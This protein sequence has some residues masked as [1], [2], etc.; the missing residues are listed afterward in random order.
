MFIEVETIND[1]KITLNVL[2]IASIA[3]AIDFVG[4]EMVGATSIAMV[5]GM[6]DGEY[7]IDT[8]SPNQWKTLRAFL[9]T[10]YTILPGGQVF[11]HSDINPYAVHLIKKNFLENKH[12][13]KGVFEVRCGNLFDIIQK[14]ERFDVIIFNPPYLPTTTQEKKGISEWYVRSFDGG[15]TG[16][17]ET[18]PFIKQVKYFLKKQGTAYIIHSSLS[19]KQKLEQLLKKTDLTYNIVKT[20]RCD[21]EILSVY[22]ISY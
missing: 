8:C 1:G 13:I 5:G 19:K 11:G 15:L 10:F 3:P 16:L 12:R 22:K 9:K 4:N 7:D 2:H 6:K 17:K 21:D 20:L 14:N 18:F